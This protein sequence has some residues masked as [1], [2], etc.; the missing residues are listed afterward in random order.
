MPPEERMA[1]HLRKT[2]GLMVRNIVI[3]SNAALWSSKQGDSACNNFATIHLITLNSDWKGV[4][5][6]WFL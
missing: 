4:V 5:F 6:S 2:Y 3:M 1:V